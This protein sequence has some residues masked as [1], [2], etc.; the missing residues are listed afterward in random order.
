MNKLLNYRQQQSAGLFDKELCLEKLSEIKNP[1]VVINSVIDFEIFRPT[2]ES[3][4]F[5][6]ERKSNAG[7]RPIDSVLMFKIFF[8]QRYYGL[9]VNDKSEI[10]F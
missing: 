9:G 7:R 2:L 10:I 3:S 1:L 5:T 6:E 8:L 4:L